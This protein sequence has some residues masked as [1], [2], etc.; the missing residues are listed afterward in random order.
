MIAHIIRPRATHAGGKDA[1]G[2]AR[3]LLTD[4]DLI[5]LASALTVGNELRVVVAYDVRMAAA[6]QAVDLV[7]ESPH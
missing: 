7:V 1:I 5:H 2:R 3:R 4:F 6:A